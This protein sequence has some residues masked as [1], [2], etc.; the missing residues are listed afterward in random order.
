MPTA[1]ISDGELTGQ[2]DGGADQMESRY[3]EQNMIRLLVLAAV[4]AR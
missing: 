3:R 4:D 1:S 2:R